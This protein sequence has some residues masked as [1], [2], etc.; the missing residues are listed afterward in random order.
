M[1]ETETQ[2]TTTQ[3]TGGL[4]IPTAVGRARIARVSAPYRVAIA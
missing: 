1:T 3:G 4:G 2:P